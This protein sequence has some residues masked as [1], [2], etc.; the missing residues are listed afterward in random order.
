MKRPHDT[1]NTCLNRM[2]IYLLKYDET[3]FKDEVQNFWRNRWVIKDIPD[4]KDSDELVYALKACI[5]ERM[6]EIWNSPPK[7]QNESAPEWCEHVK[8]YTIGFSVI[9]DDMKE[10]FK[11]YTSDIFGKRNVFAPHDFM[12]FV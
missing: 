1:P 9:P 4:P 6:V 7:N 10:I 2:V 5:V 12:F 3:S 8:P 11:S